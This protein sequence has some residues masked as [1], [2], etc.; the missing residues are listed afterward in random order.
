M[1]AEFHLRARCEPSEMIAL[2]FLNYECSFAQIVLHG[3]L[4][5]GFFRGPS[6]HHADSRGIPRK[7]FICKRINYV[8]FHLVISRIRSSALNILSDPDNRARLYSSDEGRHLY[9]CPNTHKDLCLKYCPDIHPAKA[10]WPQSPRRRT[11]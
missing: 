3:Q 5:H 4:H 2:L 1:P 7:R 11:L 8:L 9:A 10:C 6:V